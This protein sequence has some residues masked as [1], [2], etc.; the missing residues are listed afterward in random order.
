[1]SSTPGNAYLTIGPGQSTFEDWV[2]LTFYGAR[3]DRLT[4]KAY[5]DKIIPGSGIV[6]LPDAYTQTASDYVNWD[7][8]NNTFNWYWGNNGRLIMEVL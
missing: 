3:Q 1:M 2:D 8:T 4:G 5:I 6:R 7:W